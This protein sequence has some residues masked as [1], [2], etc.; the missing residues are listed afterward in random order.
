[1]YNDP[2][3]KLSANFWGAFLTSIVLL[4]LGLAAAYDGSKTN[5]VTEKHTDRKTH[6]DTDS[7]ARLHKIVAPMTQKQR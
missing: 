5:N 2:R 4:G 7:I 6:V 3:K 1:M